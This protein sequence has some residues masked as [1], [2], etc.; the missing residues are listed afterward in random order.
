MTK[1]LEGL[2]NKD[3]LSGA[4]ALL[5]A[6]KKPA[7]Q[8]KRKR[9]ACQFCKGIYVSLANL[10]KHV[11]TF[12]IPGTKQRVSDEYSLIC[13]NCSRS[14]K[15]QASLRKH[16][17]TCVAMI[18]VHTDIDIVEEES[19]IQNISRCIAE[20]E[21]DGIPARH[22]SDSEHQTHTAVSTSPRYSQ[23][24]GDMDPGTEEIQGPVD[25]EQT[26]HDNQKKVGPS[27]SDT[28][29]KTAQ[30][31]LD[32]IKKKI[33]IETDHLDCSKDDEVNEADH[34]SAN[35]TEDSWAAEH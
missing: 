35:S 11:A 8:K 12:H 22:T 33:I 6:V 10:H 15:Y 18:R 26:P 30:D 24:I 19:E 9:F 3:L 20:G 28:K 13:I 34:H 16:A 2:A 29:N 31:G 4:D 25:P 23:V 17:Q 1:K 7:K 14:F 27:N 32:G 5:K 21:S